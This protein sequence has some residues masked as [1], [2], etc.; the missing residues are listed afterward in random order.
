MR[1]KQSRFIEKKSL[2]HHKVNSILF[3][4]KINL[5]LLT[6]YFVIFFVHNKPTAPYE[7]PN[8]NDKEYLI[9][10]GPYHI[11][12][13]DQSLNQHHLC[14]NALAIHM[15]NTFRI[16]LLLF[17]F[18]GFFLIVLCFVFGVFMNDKSI[19]LVGKIQ[20]CQR[21]SSF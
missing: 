16:E 13:Q 14:N 12:V 18:V 15:A 1:N 20:H 9:K 11:I 3:Y 5:Q 19:L 21:F 7:I 2:K 17:T 10:N 6:K 4:I 8:S